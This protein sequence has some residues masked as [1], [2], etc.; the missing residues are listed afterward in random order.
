METHFHG[1]S[2]PAEAL[3]QAGVPSGH[4][5]LWGVWNYLRGFGKDAEGF[6]RIAITLLLTEITCFSS[7]LKNP[8]RNPTPPTHSKSGSPENLTNDFTYKE[9]GYSLYM[10]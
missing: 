10:T 5:A 3:A 7:G 6:L 1:S 8:K 2:L 9:L 4:V